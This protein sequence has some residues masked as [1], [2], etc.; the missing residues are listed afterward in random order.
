M[1]EEHSSTSTLRRFL[2]T[3]PMGVLQYR[4]EPDDRLVLT[5]A[6]SSAESILGVELGP[7]TGRT[8]EEVF[9]ALASTSI[10]GRYRELCG[11]ADP[12]RTERVDYEDERIRGAYE[13]HAFGT[14]PG[15]MAVLFLDITE[16]KRIE[17]A[18]RESEENYREIFNA[19]SDAIVIH[20]A[21]TGAILDVNRSMTEMFGF[22]REEALRLGP[23]DASAN[24]PP[25]TD[26]EAYRHMRRALD[27]GPQTFEWLSRRRD[28]STFWTE[29]SL[30]ATSIAGEQRLLAVV[31]DISDRKRAE[32]ALQ[33]SE[34]RYRALYES[35]GDGIFLLEN[36]RII[37]CNPR[38]CDLYGR[39]REDLLGRSPAE[40][41]P[42]RQPGGVE[43]EKRAAERIRRA[44]AGEVQSFEWLHRRPDGT[45]FEV[46]VT[47]AR[48]RIG[49]EPRVLAH[50]RDITTQKR[51]EEQL[52]HAQRMETVG[53]LA[54][55]VAHDFN[56]LL[57]PILG[58]AELLLRDAKP[59]E[60]G[61]VELEEIRR[62]ALRARAVVG[63]LLAFSRKQVL[64]MRNLDLGELLGGMKRMLRRT[65]REDIEIRLEVDPTPMVVRADPRQ[66]EQ[67]LLNLAA[68]AQD[69]MEGPGVLTIGLEAADLEDHAEIGPGPFVLLSVRDTGV[70]ID[71]ATLGRV[72]EPFFTTKEPGK[73]TGLGLATVHGIVKQHRGR[74]VG[75]S[76][77][78][79][80]SRFEVYLPRAS[81][82]VE[83]DQPPRETE[84]EE[85]SETVMVVEDDDMVRNLAVRVLQRQGYD[86]LSAE[87]AR[88]C[89]RLL[90]EHRGRMDLLLTDVIMPD[91]NGR[92]L[93]EKLLASRPGLPVLFMSGY[94]D[95]VIGSR[96]APEEDTPF[97]QKPFSLAT[98]ARRVREVLGG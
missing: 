27:E 33:A 83:R 16:R 18:L 51:L 97:I 13:V 46:E 37:D 32:E 68:N 78:G 84:V 3:S 41:S 85:G 77:P 35:A 8:I 26:E 74:I 23:R 5:G 93:H 69:A 54:G 91:M 86:V 4:L 6:N 44:L 39:S 53:Q 42:P 62:A 20:D 40:L 80:G 75:S 47:L 65:I 9:P 36:L 76:E 24:E 19:T 38:A 82:P 73:G 56:N 11:G 66:I 2:D 21:E 29:V 12:W 60:R 30:R 48:A 95:D 43:S 59:G 17:E 89:L 71:E 81:G 31:R 61:H 14:G 28:G 94:P 15:T 25:Y 88:E 67:V 79:R 57:A 98:L 49:G 70:G 10:P 64:E 22:S 58:Y 55:G 7:E 45:T 50:V 96:D 72:F 90:E 34:Q 92:E 52:A 87:S 1:G 63:Q